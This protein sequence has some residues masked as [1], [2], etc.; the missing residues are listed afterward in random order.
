MMAW[1]CERWHCLPE[2][3]GMMDQDYRMMR[4]MAAC[5]NVYNALSRLRNA[6]GEQIHQLSDNDREILGLLVRL[7]LLF[8]E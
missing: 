3:G 5:A 1:H 4:E 7:G 6:L 2:G 8:H